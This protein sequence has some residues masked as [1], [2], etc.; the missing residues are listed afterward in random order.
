MKTQRIIAT[1]LFVLAASVL[2]LLVG[3]CEET[4][5][6]TDFDLPFTEELIV[7]GF[8]TADGGGDTILITRTLP[9]LEQWTLAKAAVTDAVASV[10]SN[11]TEYPLVHVGNG[12]YR[13]AGLNPSP[14]Q[15]YTLRVAWKNLT[16]TG[17]ASIPQVPELIRLFVDTVKGGCDESFGPGQ[18]YKADE[19]RVLVEYVQHGN[20]MNSARLGISYSHDGTPQFREEGYNYI[21][22]DIDS[23]GNTN[24]AIISR[25]CY[26]EEDSYVLKMDTLFLNVAEYEPAFRNYYNTRRNGDDDNIFFGSSGESPDWNIKGNGF[27]WFFGRSTI[28][29]T[30]VLP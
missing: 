24:K 25:R 22:Y 26:A 7:Q 16:V 3:G 4:L 21:F 1:L 15:T 23:S 2:P 19:V 6:G 5:S 30:T 14:G 18:E 8:L 9:P 27:G 20:N 12:Q 13:V 17:T 28:A 11:G 10:S 29:D